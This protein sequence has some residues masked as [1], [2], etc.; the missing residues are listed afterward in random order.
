MR[1][2][3]RETSLGE[4]IDP[5]RPITYGVVQPGEHD[6]DGIPLVR[7][8]D[9][10]F[11]WRPIEQFRRVAPS[12]ERAFMRAR[13]KAGDIVI[14][15]KGDVGTAAVV[16]AYLEGANLS[17]TN[18]R[19]AIDPRRAD[20]RVVLAFLESRM[21]RKQIAAVTQVGAQPGLI[22]RDILGFRFNL[23]PLPEQRKIAA[24]LRT[25]DLGLEKLSALR[26]AKELRFKGLS[27]RLL[28]PA[29]AIGRGIPRSNW[30]LSSFGEVFS[31]R[32]DANRSLGTDDVVTVGKY[33][34]RKQ[35]EHFTRS[36]ASKDLGKYW[37]ISP[38]DFVYDPMSAYYGAIGRYGG[39]GDGLVS[40]AYRVIRLDASVDADFMTH[41]LRS[42]PVRFLLEA[43]SSQGNKEGKRRLLQRDEF[44]GIEFNLPPIEV[45]REIASRLAL[46]QRDLELT[47][48]EIAALTRQ[49]R[50]LMQKLLT[51]EWGVLV[52][53]AAA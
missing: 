51:G 11:G 42:H 26:N 6:P 7:G 14:T 39:V 35:S 32:R 21:G 27:Q 33:A 16:P 18:A 38:G 24:I 3:W 45:Q 43:R 47:D 19:L 41:L 48:R 1:D 34:I 50:G 23:P 9:F 46:V 44:A 12:I 13:L 15:I 31:E 22:F 52:E 28:A 29:R 25:W 30:T 20:V 2:C 37:I 4:L 53:G 5:K 8:G 17:Q 40:P 36:V 10:S 49:K